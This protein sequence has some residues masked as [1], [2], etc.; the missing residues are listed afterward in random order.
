M[1][2][3]ATIGRSLTVRQRSRDASRSGWAFATLLLI[4][5]PTIGRGQ[6][7]DSV[8]S[9]ARI[10]VDLRTTDRSWRGKERAQSVTG[11][12][13]EVRADTLLLT[14][15]AGAAPVR[16]PLASMRPAF[17]SRGRPPRWQAAIRGIVAPA[18]MGAAL[19]AVST[20]LHRR[21]GDPSPAAMAM[22]AAA[23]GA[24]SGAVLGAWAPKERWQRL[25]LPGT[26][27]PPAVASSAGASPASAESART[28]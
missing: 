18:L 9:D 2:T 20:S 8:A 25:T 22:S 17:V 11:T 13:A 28:P 3:G 26:A 27:Q 19:S 21:A 7:L 12:L 1:S 6:V 15:H 24:A 16:V 5:S 4:A 23:W 10:R 14:V